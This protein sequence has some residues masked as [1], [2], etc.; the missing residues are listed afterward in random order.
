[1]IWCGRGE[2]ARGSKQFDAIIDAIWR[3]IGYAQLSTDQLERFWA[4]RLVP[5]EGH[6]DPSHMP[7]MLNWL[8]RRA[9]SGGP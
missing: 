8:L 6:P 7:G 1:V 9:E 4:K 3:D 2:R 5:E